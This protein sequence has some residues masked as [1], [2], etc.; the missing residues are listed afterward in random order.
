LDSEKDEITKKA[1][2]CK[3]PAF[4]YKIVSHPP[5]PSPSTAMEHSTDAV[6]YLFATFTAATP[7]E[8]SFAPLRTQLL[9]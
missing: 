5:F 4:R 6:F 2:I 8:R 1:A 3:I 9:F 7:R